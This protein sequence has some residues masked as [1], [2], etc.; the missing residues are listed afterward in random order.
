MD[1]IVQQE[2][3]AEENKLMPKMGMWSKRKIVDKGFIENVDYI[4]FRK[5]EKGGFFFIRIK[6]RTSIIWFSNKRS[7]T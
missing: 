2:N 3:V 5:T 7:I 1:K 4:G 6:S